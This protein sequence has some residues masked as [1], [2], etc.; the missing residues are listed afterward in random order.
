MRHSRAM[1]ILGRLLLLVLAVAAAF[2]IPMNVG[3]PYYGRTRYHHWRYAEG[4][5]QLADALLERQDDFDWIANIEGEIEAGSSQ[6]RLHRVDLDEG[7]K[8]EFESL[9]ERAN[10]YYLNS[11]R[12]DDG[13]V[14]FL[15]VTNGR[16][17]G[18]GY[19]VTLL[20]KSLPRANR[21]PCRD[22]YLSGDIGSCFV[23]LD[24]NW[25]YELSWLDESYEFPDTE[26]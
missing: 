6:R 24:E 8:L 4:L 12:N 20:Y 16:R 11:S 23:S 19:Q 22:G 3:W 14:A 1:K 10:T 18:K 17:S 2:A 9:F 7:T 25:M 15:Q 26:R 21:P 5:T 13:G